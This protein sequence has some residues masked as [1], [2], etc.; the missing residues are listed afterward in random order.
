M[1]RPSWSMF[2]K[3]NIAVANICCEGLS[4]TRICV[5]YIYHILLC[6]SSHLF[7]G[8]MQIIY[9]KFVTRLYIR[10]KPYYS[11]FG[12]ILLII[13][14][15]VKGGISPFYISFLCLNVYVMMADLDS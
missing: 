3:L 10:T 13:H 9:K 11:V 12:I 1:A 14:N 4:V 8:T 7:Y 2:A 15:T 6:S 5:F